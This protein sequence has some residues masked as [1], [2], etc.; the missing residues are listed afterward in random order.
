MKEARKL[1]SSTACCD[2]VFYMCVAYTDLPMT[3]WPC[4]RAYNTL[5]EIELG[6]RL[7]FLVA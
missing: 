5:M 6:F 1:Y 2:S 7:Q 4:V 3:I